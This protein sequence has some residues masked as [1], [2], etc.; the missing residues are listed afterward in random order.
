MTGISRATYSLIRSV[1]HKPKFVDRDMLKFY[2]A[3][4]FSKGGAFEVVFN[5]GRVGQA[6]QTQ[7]I[8]CATLDAAR[9]AMTPRSPVP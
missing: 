9:K 2:K 3:Q 7:K 6:G 4:I 8:P 5:Y 1:F